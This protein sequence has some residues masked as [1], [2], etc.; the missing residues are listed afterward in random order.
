MFHKEDENYT[1][2][3]GEK[4][5]EATANTPSVTV[6]LANGPYVVKGVIKVPYPIISCIEINYAITIN[7]PLI[8]YKKNFFFRITINN[9]IL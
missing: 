2:F 6:R 4:T 9:I 8:I 1:R 5:Q 3:I 7:K